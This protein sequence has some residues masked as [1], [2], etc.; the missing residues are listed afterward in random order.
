MFILPLQALYMQ[1]IKMTNLVIKFLLELI[2]LGMLVTIGWHSTGSPLH[3]LLAILLPGVV[4][5]IWG[6]WAAPKAARRLPLPARFCLELSLFLLTAFFF[7][8]T[9]S[10][11]GALAFG[12]IALLSENPRQQ[13]CLQNPVSLCTD[14]TGV[15]TQASAAA[16]EIL[17]FTNSLL[18]IHCY[19]G[20]YF[21]HSK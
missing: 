6:R 7:Y 4:I 13:R 2:M 15:Q 17:P 20:L 19:Q 1:A 10:H 21:R 18:T 9:G 14:T 5:F 16:P 3:Y 8:Q 11:P 12:G